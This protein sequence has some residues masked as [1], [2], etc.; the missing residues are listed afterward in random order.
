MKKTLF[1][2]PLLALAAPAFAQDAKALAD[3]RARVDELEMRSFS[4]NFNISG[5]FIHTF[6]NVYTDRENRRD[7]A[8]SLNGTYVGLNVDY[9]VND[10]ISFYSTLAMSKL[11]QID[12]RAGEGGVET[13][14]TDPAGGTNG[15]VTGG[16]YWSDSFQGSSA[17]RGSVARFDRAFITYAVPGSMF[18][19]ALGRMPTS[20]GPVQNQLD[21]VE[22]TGTYPRFALN[23]IFDGVAMTVNW[24]KFLPKNHSMKTKLIYS[25]LQFAN[26]RDRMSQAQPDGKELK[27]DPLFYAVLQEYEIKDLKFAKGM[28]M[29][30]F[31]YHFEDFWWQAFND[32]YRGILWNLTVALE[33]IAGTG[34]NASANYLGSDFQG[35]ANGQTGGEGY[36]FNVN[37]KFENTHVVGAEYV[38]TNK[39][40]YTDDW[41]YLNMA[42][43]YKAA[44]NTGY[45]VF[46]GM[47]VYDN[48]RLRVGTF[49]YKVN[50]S[51]KLGIEERKV[52]SIY[53]QLRV[54][55]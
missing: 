21:G 23:A 14:T 36:L 8:V 19:F 2:L 29:Y 49:Q 34:L 11:W 44:S 48:M 15:D 6:E 31:F 40:H 35:K 33:G 10:R 18:S 52:S 4:Q 30:G 1:A 25:P 45:H 50:D 17:Y 42:D 46:W 5:T 53:T 28:Q 7:D 3:L 26:H 24:T 13:D 51:D 39:A 20:N 32:M 16:D 12:G 27:S 47:P 43:F 54:N 37:Y 9:K 55:F 41:A 38:A 22:R